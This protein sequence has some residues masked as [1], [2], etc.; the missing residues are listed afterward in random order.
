LITGS[1]PERFVP[2]SCAAK[3]HNMFIYR[4]SHLFN[5]KIGAIAMQLRCKHM[6]V[7]NFFRVMD[8][9]NAIVNNLHRI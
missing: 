5:C 3:Q 7:D 8:F 6:N 4:L 2:H 9:Q 1:F